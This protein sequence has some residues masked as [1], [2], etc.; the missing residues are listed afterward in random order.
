MMTMRSSAARRRALLCVLAMALSLL[1]LFRLTVYANDDW[2][3]GSQRGLERLL[4]GLSGYNGRYL[5]NALAVLLCRVPTLKALFMAV[6]TLGLMLVPCLMQRR[7]KALSCGLLLAGYACVLL[8]P[9]PIA[10]QTVGWVSG[11]INYAV[12]ALCVLL[13]LYGA[14]GLFLDAPALP[15]RWAGPLLFLN[16]LLGALLMENVT[17]VLAALPLA[18]Y[19]YGRARGVRGRAMLLAFAGALLGA[20]WMF[21]N[22]AYRAT[23]AGGD[24]Y[25]TTALGRSLPAMAASAWNAWQSLGASMLV[26]SNVLLLLLLA[27][28]ALFAKPTHAVGRAARAILI[29]YPL[30]PLLRRLN[31]SWAVLG[32]YTQH[33]DAA[34]SLL[35]LAALLF[36]ARF[37]AYAAPRRRRLVCY[38]L[39]AALLTAPLLLITPVSERCYMPS[40]ALLAAF[41]VECFGQALE[42]GVQLTRPLALC[43]VL[44]CVF[45][46][47]I[48]GRN[49]LCERER[50]AYLRA[51]AE[52]GQQEAYLTQL[53]YNGYTFLGTPHDADK[54]LDFLRFYGLPEDMRLTVVSYD[55]WYQLRRSL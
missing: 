43:A 11:F 22:P 51:C 29:C 52:A 2:D 48:H 7:A 32:A 39:C 31:V 10:R 9:P 44:L 23:L 21:S 53:P 24:F 47:S 18:L 27:L 37:G 1:L 16:G 20:A 34:L 4:H 49:F 33:L 14:R 26:G 55:E 35:Y 40:F 42:D 6:V 13:V 38:W 8:M 15:G 12:G 17:V 45:Y 19:V 30:Y 3:W 46:V 41:A 54:T 36:I 5:G 28:C 25:R 50:V